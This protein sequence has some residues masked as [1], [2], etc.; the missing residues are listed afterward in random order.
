MESM[1]KRKKNIAYTFAC[2]CGK[3]YNSYPALYLH[4]KRN[5][6]IKINTK[7]TDDIN[8]TTRQ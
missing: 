6:N 1:E 8:E 7:I 5:H 4:F 3:K 2:E